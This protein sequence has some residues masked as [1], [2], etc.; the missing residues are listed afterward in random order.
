MSGILS[1]ANITFREGI[2]NRVLFGILIMAILAFTLTIALTNLFINDITRVAA[3]LSLST[4]SFSGLL[5]VFFVGT[6]LVA[7]DIDKR[8]I[9]VVISRPVSRAEYI[10]GKFLGLCFL[11]GTSV[12]IL[13]IISSLPVY[14]TG[15]ASQ[16][17]LSIFKWSVYTFAVMLI[18]MKLILITSII[19]FFSSITSTSFISLILTIAAYIIGSTN[20]VVKGLLE[21]KMQGVEI[22]PATATIIKLVYYI[23]PNMS[24][25]DLKAQAVNGIPLE[26]GY[27]LW[28]TSYW[29]I[30]TSIMIAASA[31]II[32]R[33]EFP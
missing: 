12:L 15:L 29:L 33:R 16:N 10:I 32:S 14:F 25:F 6:N 13:G 2:R 4:I 1:L 19:L 5:L 28:T 17:P 21:A 3:S 11:I 20:E 18:V 9:Y 27:I 7:Q 23:F 22:G 30:Y 26:T 24:A 31:I 8:T